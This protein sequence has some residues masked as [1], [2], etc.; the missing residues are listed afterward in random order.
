MVSPIRPLFP[1][2]LEE[3]G[4][5]DASSNKGLMFDVISGTRKSTRIKTRIDYAYAQI[6]QEETSTDIGS[7]QW[8]G[9]NLLYRELTMDYLL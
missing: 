9:E 2:D 7:G 6:V 8:V 4:K 5:E 3:I 1:T